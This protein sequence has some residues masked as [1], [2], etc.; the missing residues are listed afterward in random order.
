MTSF[1]AFARYT[2]TRACAPAGAVTFDFHN[3]DDTGSRPHNLFLAAVDASGEIT[4]A[5]VEIV[6]LRDNGQ[7]GSGTLTVK[8]GRYLLICTVDGHQ[9]MNTPFQVY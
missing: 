8:A 7:G 4:G 5:P 6:G 3:I 1:D 9:G 2:L